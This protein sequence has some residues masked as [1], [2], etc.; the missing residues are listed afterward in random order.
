M[1]LEWGHGAYTLR[2]TS[3]TMNLYEQL[4]EVYLTVI[5][6]RAVIPQFRVMLDTEGKSWVEGKRVGWSAFPD[7]LAVDF[8]R[9]EIQIVEVTSS[10]DGAKPK[11]LVHKM[12]GNRQT[13]EDYTRTFVGNDFPIA[14]R[15]FVRHSLA[16]NL[17]AELRTNQI[18]ASVTTLEDVFDALKRKMPYTK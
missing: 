6:R 12:L 3:P 17:E 4:V 18:E 13:I 9:K 2:V 10:A 8:A 16:N 5:E 15:F 1:F 14:W 7:F 11:E